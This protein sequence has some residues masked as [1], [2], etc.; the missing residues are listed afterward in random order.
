MIDVG[1]KG[2]ITHQAGLISILFYRWTACRSKGSVLF[3][4]VFFLVEQQIV[5]RLQL[6]LVGDG[7]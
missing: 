2:G 3:V 1:L 4:L 5:D 7:L 6:F